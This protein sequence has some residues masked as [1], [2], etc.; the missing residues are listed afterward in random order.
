MHASIRRN[1]PL[2]A[3]PATGEVRIPLA[4]YAVDELRGCAD[5]VMSRA[6]AQ[7]VFTELAEA[8]G[9]VHQAPVQRSLEAVR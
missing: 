2:A 7:A 6:E 5:L 3:V 9:C 4:L 8:L 1:E